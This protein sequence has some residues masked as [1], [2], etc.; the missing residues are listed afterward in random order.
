VLAPPAIPLR[1]DAPPTP[2]IPETQL[3]QSTTISSAPVRLLPAPSAVVPLNAR[4]QLDPTLSLTQE[5][6][7]NFNLTER[8]KQDNF[9]STVAPGLSLTINGAFLK[10]V[11][12]YKFSPAYDTSTDEVSLFHNLLAQLTWDANPLWRLTLSEA[13]TRSDQPGEADRLGLRQQRQ[14]FTSNTLQLASDYIISRIVTRQAYVLSTFSDDEGG[15]T[16]SHTFSLSAAVPVYQTN[17]VSAGYE[18]LLSKS[19]GD[20]TTTTT[21][22]TGTARDTDVVGHKVTLSA[23]RQVN[24]LRSVGVTGSYALRDTTGGLS[25]DSQ[26]RIWNASVFTNYE[27]PRRLTLNTTLGI[28][29]LTGDSGQSVGPN[30]STKTTLSYQ[31][32]RALVSLAIDRG[33]SETFTEGENFG[34]VETEGASA[35]LTYPFTPYISGTLS[36]NYRRSKTTNVGGS[37]LTTTS[38]V[39]TQQDEET[40]TWGGTL[41]F[42]WRVMQ[43]VLFE[44]SYSYVRQEGSETGRG[45]TAVTTTG[46]RLTGFDNTY[47]EN[48]IKASVDISF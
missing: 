35:S 32:A 26:F 29:G 41:S 34:V 28:S 2:V 16:T 8:D 4:F 20:G 11:V 17:T 37:A 43:R 24:T 38:G 36:G 27:L 10:G 33:F 23:S 15:D 39:G 45:G 25:G 7:D 13:L 31:F 6:T 47:T 40:E 12:S 19:T 22:T 42:R 14:S 5:Y 48:R 1:P 44:L 3:I 9:R 21:T 46:G 30:F 18:Y